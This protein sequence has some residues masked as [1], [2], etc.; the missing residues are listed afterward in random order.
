M[1]IDNTIPGADDFDASN[2]SSGSTKN[3]NGFSKD[4][5]PR[6]DFLK[7]ER[8]TMTY[9]RRIGNKIHIR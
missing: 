5:A 7:D 3:E 4:A 8:S 9:G 1:A 6:I 2:K